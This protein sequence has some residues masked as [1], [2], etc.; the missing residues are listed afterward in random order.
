MVF[1]TLTAL[2]ATTAPVPDAHGTVVVVHGLG[3]HSGR[4]AHVIDALNRAQWTV[5]AYDQR[6]FGRSP[7]ARG[8]LPHENVLLDDLAQIL[9]RVRTKKRVLL[10][11]SMGGAVAARFVADDVR[12]VDA[13]I[14][15]SPALKRGLN[16]AE[17]LK[18]KIGELVAPNHAIR[19]GLD[20][21]KVSHDPAVVKAYI[22][23][24]LNHDLITP[25]LARFILDS[26]NIVRARAKQWRV[27]T[28]LMWAGDDYLVDA[29]GSREFGKNAPED[30]V[31]TREFPGLYHEIF[32]EREP[33]V[34]ETMRKWL[35]RT[36]E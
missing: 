36:C 21:A 2:H 27:A 13:L 33:A 23:D 11:H 24:P 4:Y 29:N 10:G 26:G 7:G 19:N 22:D 12:N 30:I 17:R 18:L 31:T 20:P 34:F 6:G 16:L 15:S 32:N 28:L 25:R 5:V 35:A 14:L 1:E 3:E 8:A 9:D